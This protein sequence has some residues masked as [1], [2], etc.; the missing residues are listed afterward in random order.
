[1]PIIKKEPAI[2]HLIL[3]SCTSH[4]KRSDVI[5]LKM[6]HAIIKLIKMLLGNV[7]KIEEKSVNSLRP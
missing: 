4:K 7:L 3:G 2:G 5:A 6:I 1:M